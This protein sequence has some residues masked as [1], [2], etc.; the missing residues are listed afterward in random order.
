MWLAT[1]N[2]DSDVKEARRVIAEAR[3][4]KPDFDYSTQ[5]WIGLERERGSDKPWYWVENG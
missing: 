5:T 3:L 2:C 1:L 4:E